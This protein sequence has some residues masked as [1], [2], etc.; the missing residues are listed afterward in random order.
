MLIRSEKGTSPPFQ[1]EELC[2]SFPLT[3]FIK[4]PLTA[5]SF[6]FLLLESLIFPHYGNSG[7]S[8]QS[9][10]QSLQ[11]LILKALLVEQLP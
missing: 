11:S 8:H 4:S 6:L 3:F 2:P 7:L 5:L 1:F 9:D 10:S